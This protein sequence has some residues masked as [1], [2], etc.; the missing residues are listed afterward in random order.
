LLNM[1]RDIE[2][3]PFNEKM[4]RL[5]ENLTRFLRKENTAVRLYEKG[6]L[7][8]KCYIFYSDRPGQQL[9]FERFKPVVAIVGSSNLTGPGLTSNR[10]LNLA[11]KV[12]LEESEAED[13]EAQLAVQWLSEGWPSELIKPRNRQLIK[14]EVGARAIIE[15]DNW[16]EK[17]WN[18]SRDFKEDLIGLLNASKFGALEYTPYQIYMKALY[19]YFRDDLDKEFVPSGKS[20]IDLTLFQEHAVEKARKILSRYDGVMITDSVGLGK[21]FIGK[22]LLEDF[23]YHMRQKAIVVCP[24]SLRSMWTE[25]LLSISTS[26]KILSQEELGQVDFPAERYGDA[27]VILIDESHNFRNKNAQRYDNLGRLIAHN[28]GRGRDGLRKKLILVTATPINN[29]LF[30]LYHQ[31]S[32]FTQG[33]RSYFSAAGI[34]DL[35][36]YF[37]NARRQSIGGDGAV[38]L[39]NLLEEVVIRR[40]RPFIRQAYPEAFIRK[41]NAAGEIVEQKVTFPD[42]R[43]KT[44]RYDLE[45]TYE[46]LY[47]QIVMGVENLKLA[48]YNLESYKKEGVEVDEFEQGREKAL[49]GIFKSRYLKRF[50]SSIEAFK[51]SVRRALEFQQTFESYVL[52]GKVLRSSDFHRALRYVSREDEEDDAMPISRADELDSSEEA[53]A[54]LAEMEEVDREEYDLRRLHDALQHDI[55]ILSDIWARVRGIKPED[56]AK[57]ERFKEL[58]AKELKGQKVIVFSYYKDTTRYVYRELTADKSSKFLNKLGN[59]TIRRMDGG[60]GPKDR[61]RVVEAFA[62]KVNNRPDWVGSDKEIDILVSTDVLSEGQNLQDCGYL[63]NYDLH[64]NPTRMVQRAGRIDRLGTD[65]DELWIHNMFPEE[66]LERLLRLVES[67]S[68]KIAQIDSAGFLDASVLGE[69]VHPRNFNTLRRIHDEDGTIIDEQERFTELASSEYMLQQL[70][71][72]LDSEGNEWLAEL[73]DGIHSGLAKRAEKGLFFYFQTVP[74]GR[75]HKLHFWKYYDLT[76][77]RIIDNRYLISSLIACDRDTPRVVGDYDVF[78]I[79]EKIIEDILKTHQQRRGLEVAP[80]T[81]DPAQQVVAT[82]LQGYLNHPSVSRQKVT[83]AIRFLSRPFPPALVKELKKLHAEF[84][85]SSDVGAFVEDI[86]S[87]ADKYGTT[88]RVSQ[89]TLPELQRE[90]LKLICFDYVCS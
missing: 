90:D 14:S 26:A 65:F 61:E 3:L 9:L 39:F 46:G 69:T 62:P 54:A 49:V 70:R 75:E 88:D 53:K 47:D 76:Q 45:S 86:C 23:A 17:Q 52:D 48:P 43:L 44:I 4:L 56:D 73:P 74:A 25:E 2:Q 11:H 84:K 40:T 29:D 72:L 8:A 60:T 83:R 87:M 30:D 28:G 50:E 16:F 68:N 85:N 38:A 1:R 66:G 77:E 89:E 63:V 82:T 31:I 55:R 79:Q 80:K 22:K 18:D 34:G 21:T 78:E 81:V 57:L 67:L 19:E 32:L 15:L 58:L 42:R 37:I 13:K 64:W 41:P 5:I 24:A 59:P 33:D 27:D 36:R 51:I 71:S 20:A 6:I 7:H 12:L 10:E 35:H